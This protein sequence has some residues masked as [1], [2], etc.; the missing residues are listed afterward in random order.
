MKH[1][2]FITIALMTYFIPTHLRAEAGVDKP[3]PDFT[4]TDSTGKKRSLKEF[5]GKLIVLEWVDYDCPFVKK[6]YDPGEM[7]KLQKEVT[8]QGGVWISIASSM[9][10]MEGFLPPDEIIARSKKLGTHY[11]AYLID[12]D[13]VV[14]K[15]YGAKTTPHIFIIDPKGI[16]TYAGAIDTI[17]SFRTSDVSKAKNLVRAALDEMKQGKPVSIKTYR[18]Y[19]C[20]IK[21]K[22]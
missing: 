17:Y 5:K 10:G 4:L 7:Q 3:A 13:G 18:P 11:T 1:F 14:G 19:G 20:G 2:L 22:P 21:Y 16:V 6:F 8:D 12:S 9:P 15:K